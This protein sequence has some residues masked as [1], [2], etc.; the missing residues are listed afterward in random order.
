MVPQYTG[1][2]HCAWLLSHTW[3]QTG[4]AARLILRLRVGHTVQHYG[5]VQNC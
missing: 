5:F 2:A 3:T 1:T 4:V